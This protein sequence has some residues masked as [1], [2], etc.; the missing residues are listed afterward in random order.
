MYEGI[1]LVFIHSLC[2]FVDILMS[3][4]HSFIFF[5]IKYEYNITLRYLCS[6]LLVF[7]KL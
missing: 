6:F 2:I 7:S 4:I 1:Y 3:I 5:N